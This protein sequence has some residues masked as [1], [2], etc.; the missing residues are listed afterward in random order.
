MTANQINDYRRLL[1]QDFTVQNDKLESQLSYITTGA[2]AFFA[3][4]LA[5]YVNIHTTKYISFFILGMTS[6][7]IAFALILFRKD[8]VI[9]YNLSSTE[10][11]D[12]M[13]IDSNTDE[14]CFRLQWKKNR[15][16]LDVIRKFVY[17]TLFVGI[18]LPIVFLCLNLKHLK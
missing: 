5:Q 1:E 8:R 7:C 9:K 11:L 2:L 16:C 3:T 12:D 17:C 18:V 15:K 10:F 4:F 6:L 13:S 14:Q